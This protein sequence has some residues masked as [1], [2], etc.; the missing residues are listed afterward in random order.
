MDRHSDSFS[1]GSAG[2]DSDS[3]SDSDSSTHTIEHNPAAAA[4]DAST[5]ATDFFASSFQFSGRTPDR[6]H[7]GNHV[8]GKLIN[9]TKRKAD[10]DDSDHD[11]TKAR[12]QHFA[13]SLSNRRPMTIVR[14][15]SAQSDTSED[16]DEDSRTADSE[17]LH[18]YV[19]SD[20]AHTSHSQFQPRHPAHSKPTLTYMQQLQQLQ[21]LPDKPPT[22]T[23]STPPI[24]PAFLSSQFGQFTAMQLLRQAL[25]HITDIDKKSSTTRVFCNRFVA[26]MPII[27]RV[28]TSN[29][30]QNVP[31]YFMQATGK[32]LPAEEGCA[33]CQ[34]ANGV[35]SGCVIAT[36]PEGFHI[37]QGACANCWYGRQGSQCSFRKSEI[38]TKQDDDEDDE[39]YQEL[40]GGVSHVETPTPASQP[41][42]TR[43]AFAMT[44]RGSQVYPALNETTSTTTA[45]AVTPAAHTHP[46]VLAPQRRRPNTEPPT[47]AP[48]A[49]PPPKTN[50]TPSPAQNQAQAASQPPSL[51]AKIKAWESRYRDMDVSALRAAQEHL[52]QWQEDLSTRVMAMNRVYLGILS[53]AEK[54]QQQGG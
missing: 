42:N 30:A 6:S 40:A 45:A 44:T 38:Y 27:Q 50:A 10:S 3:D 8:I 18:P 4:T 7:T 20:V 16:D 43:P 9:N 11:P 31:S 37:T 19:G 49:V 26:Q 46:H 15:P 29:K 47:T 32:L 25:P 24:H 28:F 21:Q 1:Q 5:Y 2:S 41:V 54:S 48:A 12:K 14:G 35:Y 51:D 34:R 36:D 39:T 52:M 33:R 53:D 22:H 17:S 23:T 13:N